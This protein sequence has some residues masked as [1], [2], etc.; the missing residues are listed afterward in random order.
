MNALAA[1]A[2]LSLL[3]YVATR[4]TGHDLRVLGETG[5]SLY[6]AESSVQRKARV[7][8]WEEEVSVGTPERV[9]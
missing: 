2:A 5:G 6:F 9:V 7:G 8:I 1:K 4:P 3:E